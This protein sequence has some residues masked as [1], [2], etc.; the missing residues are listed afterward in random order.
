MRKDFGVKYWLYPLPVL[1]VGS[2]DENGTPNAM[3]AAWGGVSAADQVYM[4]LLSSHKTVRN[5]LKTKAFTVS[6]ATAKYAA[7]CD[8][9]GIESA[10]KVPDKLKRCG[11]HT[12]KSA[13]VN[14]PLIDELPLTLECEL[15]SYDEDTNILIGRI[16]NV[17]ADED[18]LTD[19]AVDVAKLDPIAVDPV[20]WAYVRLGEPVGK[21][22]HSGEK[23]K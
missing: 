9:V 19:G 1:I 22:F 7:E 23:F 5:I 10:N 14:A 13:F 8:Y 12:T 11:L 4:S 6:P 2:Y 21:A 3:N 15:I 18:I 20:S 16:V 17:S